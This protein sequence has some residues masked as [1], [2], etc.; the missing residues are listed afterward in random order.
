[1]LRSILAA[2]NEDAGLG[3][4]ELIESYSEI[5][6]DEEVERDYTNPLA[7][8]DPMTRYEVGDEVEVN[9]GGAPSMLPPYPGWYRGVITKRWVVPREFDTLD[10]LPLN[11]FAMP[12][13]FPYAVRTEHGVFPAL[14][15]DPDFVRGVAA[16]YNT[17]GELRFAVGDVVECCIGPNEW[18]RGTVR[19][20]HKPS[21]GWGRGWDYDGNALKGI[22][23]DTMPY[24]V[25]PAGKTF[26][27]NYNGR[28]NIGVPADKDG[29]VR[30]IRRAN[31]AAVA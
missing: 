3:E 11:K 9:L 13:A 16:K 22:V 28:T 29:Y 21:R 7:S 27:G 5:S 19:E 26:D 23:K 30:L 10:Q 17:G 14:Q 20:L 6:P 31:T 12:P 15:D 2:S 1:M 4:P 8:L 24:H 18:M 25:T